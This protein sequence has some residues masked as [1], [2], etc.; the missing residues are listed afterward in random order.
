MGG[1][2]QVAAASGYTGSCEPEWRAQE[3]KRALEEL[4]PDIKMV[5][6]KNLRAIMPS[7]EQS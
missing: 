4:A 6:S 1:S 3:F 2:G 7:G 5:R